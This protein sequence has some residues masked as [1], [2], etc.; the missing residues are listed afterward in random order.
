MAL[1]VHYNVYG[2]F[3]SPTEDL[4]LAAAAVDAGFAGVWIGDHFHPWIDSRPYTHHVVPWLGALM[5]RVPDVPVGTSVTCPIM[6]YDPVLLAQ[7]YATLDQ[8][9]PGRLNIGVGTG[10]ALNEMSFHDGEWPSWGTRAEML[11]E[12]IGLMRQLWSSDAYLDH[13]GEHYQYDAIKLHTR[14]AAPIDIHWAAWGPQSCRA[15][16]RFAD[17]LI[18]AASPAQIAETI[19]PN[20]RRGLATAGRDPAEVDVTT[21]MPACVGPPAS[22]TAEIR[23]RG[24]HI[25]G[26]A[27]LDNPDPRDIQRVADAQLAT[28]SDAEIQS[29]NN[30]TDDPSMLL[31]ELAALAD[32]GVTRVLVGSPCGDPQATIDVFADEILPAVAAW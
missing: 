9:A 13:T 11:I 29:H 30:I 25:P 22:L 7:A 3:R 4:D 19:V 1:R 32:A 8:L 6:R 31:D 5:Q 23:E 10:E 15:A 26:T 21:E 27:E 2:C 16:G 17:H 18:T 14:P 28:M 12:A 24:E 20:L